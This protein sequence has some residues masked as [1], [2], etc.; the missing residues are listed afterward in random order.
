M[1]QAKLYLNG[2]VYTGNNYYSEA[3]TALDK[4]LGGPYSIEDDY[5]L[6]FR[7]DNH[8][9]NELIFTLPSDG[10]QTQ[11]YGSTTFLN[12]WFNRWQYDG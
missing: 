3:I 6:N 7:A 12:K 8:T 11:G 2:E 5:Q 10:I 1:L 4:I 9:S